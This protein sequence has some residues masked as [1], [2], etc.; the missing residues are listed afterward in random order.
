MKPAKTLILAMLTFLSAPFAAAE[1]AA[2]WEDIFDGGGYLD[3]GTSALWGADGHL[4]A[5][6]ISSDQYNNISTHIR[7]LDSETG[8]LIWS[9][10]Y[11][12]SAG[13]SMVFGGF[14]EDNAGDILI[15]AYIQICG[16]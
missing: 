16:S 6:G 7:K 5:G 8:E 9:N 14:F 11:L 4:I 2:Q 13:N 10:G 3:T 12:A 15:G 1:P